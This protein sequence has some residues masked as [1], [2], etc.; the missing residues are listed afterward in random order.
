VLADVKQKDIAN[1]CAMNKYRTPRKVL[2]TT[3]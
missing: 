3:Y 1:V 2:R